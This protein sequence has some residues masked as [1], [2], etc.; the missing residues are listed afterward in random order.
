MIRK[1]VLLALLA[2]AP[3]ASS[4]AT[5]HG[6]L[7]DIKMVT[8]E[9]TQ[10]S[11]A[12]PPQAVDHRLCLSSLAGYPRAMAAMMSRQGCTMAKYSDQAGTVTFLENC[13]RHVPEVVDGMFRTS[14]SGLVGTMRERFL[15]AGHMMEVDEQITGTRVG[16]CA[17]PGSE[18]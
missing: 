11:Q 2:V 5:G 1:L 18:E 8:T 6:V 10:G 14:A 9:H 12:T 13:T 4:A 17:H 3:I 7:V 16:N 15:V